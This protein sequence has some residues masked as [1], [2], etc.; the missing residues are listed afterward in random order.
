MENQFRM[1]WILHFMHKLFSTEF[2]LFQVQV[3]WSDAIKERKLNNSGDDDKQLRPGYQI[4]DAVMQLSSTFEFSIECTPVLIDLLSCAF[5]I[6]IGDTQHWMWL[7]FGTD[8]KCVCVGW[9]AKFEEKII[10]NL[11]TI[12]LLEEDVRSVQKKEKS[13]QKRR[14]PNTVCYVII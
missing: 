5:R 6:L 3:Y 7:W 9:E 8:L 2:S 12:D 11:K 4:P 10:A 13:Q 14:T 1:I